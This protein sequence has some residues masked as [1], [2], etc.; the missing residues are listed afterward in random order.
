MDPRNSCLSDLDRVNNLEIRITYRSL[1]VTQT[2]SEGKNENNQTSHRDYCDPV[3][4]AVVSS[5]L[6][7]HQSVISC[8][9]PPAI[10]TSPEG[11]NLNTRLM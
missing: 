11:D 7:R 1:P 2:T 6:D 4:T 3:V 8:R 10:Q 5:D 9:E